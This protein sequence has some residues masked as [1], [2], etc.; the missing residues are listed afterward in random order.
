MSAEIVMPSVLFL[1]GSWNAPSE[2]FLYRQMQMLSE[3]HVLEA[4]VAAQLVGDKQWRNIPV[5]GLN[6]RDA[7][8]SD[9][10][11]DPVNQ[12]TLLDQVLRQ[13][14]VDT[15]L[16]Q[17]GTIAVLLAPLLQSAWQR[18]FIHVH[19]KDTEEQMNPP[20]YRTALERLAQRGVVMCSP[21]VAERLKNWDIP[22]EH[23]VVKNYGVEI[24]ERPL[25]RPE[26]SAVTILHVGRL[27]ECKGPDLTIRAFEHACEQGLKGQLVMI[28]DGPMRGVCEELK[29]QSKWQGRINLRG[30]IDHE[31]VQLQLEQADIFT[32]H[33]LRGPTTGQVEAFGV[34]IVE[35]MAAALPVVS[36]TIGGVKYIVIDGETGIL[37]DPGDIAGQAKAFLKLATTPTLRAHLGKAGWDRAQNYYSYQKEKDT[38]LRILTDHHV[39]EA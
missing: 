28:G 36:C 32:Q 11:P 15:I 19:G 39:N 22:R 3:A 7:T 27:I 1:M 29:A 33:S 4:V 38:L 30:A 12:L 16:C 20:G 31:E 2:R 18:L 26:S 10:K 6:S 5:F 9:S 35:A 8:G 25:Q 14:R 37:V 24:P 23:I 17:Y 21:Y 13:T 34:A